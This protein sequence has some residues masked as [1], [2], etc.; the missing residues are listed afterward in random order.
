MKKKLS[1]FIVFVLCFAM[2]FSFASCTGLSD[3]EPTDEFVAAEVPVNTN[4]PVSEAEIIAF[5]N[6]IITEIQKTDIF[7]AE[8]KPGVKLNESLYVDDI[9]ILSIGADGKEVENEKL[10]TLNKSAKAIKDRILSEI[11]TD[12][13]KIG[14][15]D[16]KTPISSLIY[17]F[18]GTSSLTL[19]NV[20]DAQ[21]SVDGN[22]LIISIKLTD[23]LNTIETMFGTRNK[24]ALLADINKNTENYAAISDYSVEYIADEESN[25]F[26]TIN[27]VVEVVKQAD[28][29]YRCTGRIM[30]LDIKIICN[31]SAQ[32]TGLNSFADYGDMKLNFKFTDEKNYEFDWLGNATWEPIFHES[33][34][35]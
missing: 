23:D 34:S 10:A 14:F 20:I 15:G 28:G 32:M 17:P 2:L 3:D 16:M 6:D 5:Y 26:S 25:T 12:S 7:T 30:S 22:D 9:A 18:D 13:A 29:K 27:L 24:E 31:V 35:E 4:I 33:E 1:I 21:C 19:N 11:I 8:N